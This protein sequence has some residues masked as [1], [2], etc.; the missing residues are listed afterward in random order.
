MYVRVYA[1]CAANAREI[2]LTPGIAANLHMQV[3]IYSFGVLAIFHMLPLRI[4]MLG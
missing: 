3:G 1:Y 2:S 4:G